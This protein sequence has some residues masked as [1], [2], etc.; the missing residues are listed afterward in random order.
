MDDLITMTSIRK[1]LHAVKSI[2]IVG[3]SPNE[4]RPSNMV[5]KYLLKVGYDVVPVNPGQNE[6]LGRR[7]YPDL[8]SIPQK[9][10]L[11]DI[12][13]KSDDV[14]PIVRQAI[15]KKVCGVWMQLGIKNED[16]ARLA[17]KNNVAVIM[18][19]CIKID[20][21]VFFDL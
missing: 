21:Q 4:K 11:V 18:N 2:A 8:A 16:A 6:I 7:C 15:E 3:L 17:L 9:I 10:D 14:L 13:R 5:G 19:R 20:H 1:L 12:F